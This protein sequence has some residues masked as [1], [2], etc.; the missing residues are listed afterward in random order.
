MVFGEII[1]A[2]K[3]AFF[4]VYK[5]LSLANAIVNPIEMHVDGFGSF[6]LDGVIGNAVGG[7]VIGLDGGGR[8]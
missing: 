2:V 7:T 5:K 4:P 8:L 3:S 1:G 6:L